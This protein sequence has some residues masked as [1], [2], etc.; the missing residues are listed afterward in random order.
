MNTPSERPADSFEEPLRAAYVLMR[1]GQ[2]EEACRFLAQA[3]EHALSGGMLDDAALYSSVRGSYLAAMGHDSDALEAYLEAERLSDSDPHSCL[4]TTRH[5]VS[6]MEQPGK[7][8]EKVDAILESSSVGS[9]VRQAARAIRGLA[10]LALDQSEKALEELRKMCSELPSALLP[11]RS[12]DLTLVEALVRKNLAPSLCSLY[13]ESV[14]L[15]AGEEREA[16]VLK[17]VLELKSYISSS[18]V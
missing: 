18:P 5:L 12:C 6:C 10:L 3:R 4:I 14:E 1:E 13:L 8:L 11:S 16:R 2:G 15:R 17:K 7:A 9:A